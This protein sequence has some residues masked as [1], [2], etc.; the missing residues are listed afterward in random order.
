MRRN[1]ILRCLAVFVLAG[2]L[3]ACG[4]APEEGVEKK[5][6]A[7]TLW[8][9]EESMQ[10]YVESAAAEYKKKSGVQVNCEWVDSAHYLDQIYNASMDEEQTTPDIYLLRNDLLGEACMQGTAQVNLSAAYTKKNYCQ[11]ALDAATFQNKLMGYPLYYKTSCMIYNADCFEQAPATMGAITAY[12]QQVQFDET[13]QYILYWD[14]KDYLC[15]YS[16][17]G[18]YLDIGG[19]C[20]DDRDS[21]SIVNDETIQCLQQYQALGQFFAIDSESMNADVVP[22]ALMEGRTLCVLADCDMVHIINYY[23]QN[24]GVEV[25]YHI[26]R[27]PDVTDE[28]KS[29]SGSYTELVL[30]NGLGLQQDEAGSFAEYLTSD[31]VEKLYD[32]TGHFAAKRGINYANKEFSQLYEI[33]EQSKQFPKLPETQDNHLWLD[34]LFANVWQGEDITAQLQS[35]SDKITGR[36]NK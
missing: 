34:V 21:I 26:C 15:N 28:L 9:T 22:A 36:L 4:K 6:V 24:N 32:K 3:T 17:V 31:Y 33:Y 7:L 19:K 10:D 25:P 35:Y 27:I 2:V 18:N 23:A 12:A 29:R 1:M 14:V 16:F 30:V 11:T 5:K 20:G 8:Y 13:M